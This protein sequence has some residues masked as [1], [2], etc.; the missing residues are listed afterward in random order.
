VRIARLAP[1][2]ILL[3]SSCYSRIY[4]QDD[5]KTKG[6]TVVDHGLL[7]LGNDRESDGDQ[8]DLLSRSLT[9]YSEV[10]TSWTESLKK[11]GQV[12]P[13]GAIRPFHVKVVNSTQPNAVAICDNSPPVIEVNSALLRALYAIAAEQVQ[14]QLARENPRST[15]ESARP[16]MTGATLVRALNNHAPL[17]RFDM[18]LCYWEWSAV[19]GI[20]WDKHGCRWPAETKAFHVRFG[21][22]TLEHL[23]DPRT[24]FTRAVGRLSLE[25]Q[26]SLIWI[27][28]HEA[29]HLWFQ[30]CGVPS[31]M[32][33][34]TRADVHGAQMVSCILRKQMLSVDLDMAMSGTRSP[35]EVVRQAYAIAN[36]AHLRSGDGNHEDLDARLERVRRQLDSYSSGIGLYHLFDGLP[37]EKAQ[38]DGPVKRIPMEDLP[39]C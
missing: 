21:K 34:E 25:Y 19:D 37:V 36:F 12:D 5:G 9:T 29:Y 24:L 20:D 4:V 38:G 16:A 2:I 30:E 1:F 35:E 33:D 3:L 18:G 14:D 39:S 10:L 31:T 15:E 17:R 28:G 6:A 11:K 26:I 7:L 32:E 23:L 8:L 22:V 27:L 13:P